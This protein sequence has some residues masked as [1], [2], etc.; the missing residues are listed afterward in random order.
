MFR[1]IATMSCRSTNWL[2][3][4]CVGIKIGWERLR[5]VNWFFDHTAHYQHLRGFALHCSR[6]LSNWTY[7]HEGKWKLYGTLLIPY[8][9]YTFCNNKNLRFP[10]TAY[11]CESFLLLLLSSSS[12][13]IVCTTLD[14]SRSVQQFYPTPVYP[15]PSPSNEQFSS[16]LGL[17]L[18]GPSTLT[19]VSLLV[20]FYMASILLFFW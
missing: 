2:K 8:K 19:S 1:Q 4:L 12:S 14:G 5:S 11:L 6:Y 7:I 3:W 13:S 20:L 18:P 15:R 16:S 9:R 17:L 10:R